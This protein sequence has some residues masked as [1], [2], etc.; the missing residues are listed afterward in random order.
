MKTDDIESVIS[1]LCQIGARAVAR[2]V[3][4]TGS[5]PGDMPEYF[6]PAYIFDHIGDEITMTLETS[7]LKLLGWSMDA[8]GAQRSQTTTQ[9]VKAL[10]EA[11]NLGSPRVDLV[12]FKDPHLPKDE[13]RILALVEFKRGWIDGAQIPGRR[14][15]RDKLLMLLNHID[16]SQYGVVCGWAPAA[17]R[18]WARN[19]A[20]TVGDSWFEH[21]FELEGFPT[22]YYFC[23][24][25]FGQKH[26]QFQPHET[27]APEAP[28]MLPT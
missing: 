4:I 21:Q 3:E 14:S 20:M 24:R 11:A 26:R 1:E 17:N 10:T 25:L 5:P 28:A 2:Y 27:T 15:D 12:V 7:F 8:N 23:A 13:Q 9:D 18:D 6:M 19:D 22:S 16:T